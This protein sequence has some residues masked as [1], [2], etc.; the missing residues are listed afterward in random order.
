MRI[1]QAFCIT[2]AVISAILLI[3]I[4]R[5]IRNSGDPDYLKP[6]AMTR[7]YLLATGQLTEEPQ[8]TVEAEEDDIA[9]AMEEPVEAEEF[10]ED[11]ATDDG[12]KEEAELFDENDSQLQ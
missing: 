11:A 12:L 6:Y 5:K 10:P 8:E 9:P 2:Y 7:E 1:S 4:K 3:V